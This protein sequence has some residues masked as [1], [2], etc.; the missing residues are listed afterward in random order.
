MLYGNK[1]EYRDSVKVKPAHKEMIQEYAE[2]GLD[3]T[4]YLDIADINLLWESLPSRNNYKYPEISEL[5]T[6]ICE[7][8]DLVRDIDEYSFKEIYD[9]FESLLS[10]FETMEEIKWEKWE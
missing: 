10:F 6:R 5:L 2:F 1:A 4:V 8:L 9:G 3:E 7:D